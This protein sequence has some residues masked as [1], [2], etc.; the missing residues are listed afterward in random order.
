VTG[1]AGKPIR[2]NAKGELD[3]QGEVVVKFKKNERGF[4]AVHT[5]DDKNGIGD[6]PTSPIWGAVTKLQF[7]VAKLTKVMLDPKIR[8]Q[9]VG[10]IVPSTEVL[11]VDA[12]RTM[13]TMFNDLSSTIGDFFRRGDQHSRG[14]GNF[15]GKGLVYL[16]AYYGA[17]D[18]RSSVTPATRIIKFMTL[19]LVFGAI[20]GLGLGAFFT[21]L[22]AMMGFASTGVFIGLLLGSA[23]LHGGWGAVI[24]KQLS[25]DYKEG[26]GMQQLFVLNAGITEPSTP[27][28]L[29]AIPRAYL[30]WFKGD[31]TRVIEL[32]QAGY[33]MKD[34]RGTVYA[35]GGYIV[36]ALFGLWIVKRFILDPAASG[37]GNFFSYVG[38]GGGATEYFTSPLIAPPIFVAVAVAAILTHLY[39][40]FASSPD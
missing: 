4:R 40:S 14:T 2:V 16:D 39:L 38:N 29:T 6:I 23:A 5:A 33:P 24:A 7:V 37:Y 32:F 26:A 1:D 15:S 21:V 34:L 28:F 20:A 3:P 36:S 25:H 8:E 17:G 13:Y 9:G 31:L 30:R 19:G 18:A 12:K 11:T 10:V 22:L 27:D 35:L